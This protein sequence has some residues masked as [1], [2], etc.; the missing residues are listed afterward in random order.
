M[1]VAEYCKNQNGQSLGKK[2]S[3]ENIQIDLIALFF[4]NNN[5]PKK[6]SDVNKKVEKNDNWVTIELLVCFGEIKIVIRK[7][8]LLKA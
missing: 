6:G 3:P 8:L 2:G 5:H 1:F 4:Q 7:N